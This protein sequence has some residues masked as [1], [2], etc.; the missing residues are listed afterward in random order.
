MGRDLNWFVALYFIA[1][2]IR[3]YGV[4]LE[5][6]K[7]IV[8]FISAII[9]MMLS[10]I[11]IGAVTHTIFGIE[12]EQ[13]L[14]LCFNSVFSCAASVAAFLIF[15]DLRINNQKIS[16]IINSISGLMLGVY[17]FHENPF[18]RSILWDFIDPTRYMNSM[19]GTLLTL[20]YMLFVCFSIMVIGCVLEKIR[21]FLLD[22]VRGNYF[23]DR[24]AEKIDK[25]IDRINARLE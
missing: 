8:Y 11:I 9:L 23:C 24:V 5:K 10:L 4:C 17:L 7:L 20:F 6:K 2:Y 19:H 3:K 22:L 21:L 12:K 18:I 13:D 14:M 1:A 15:L 25:C 16:H